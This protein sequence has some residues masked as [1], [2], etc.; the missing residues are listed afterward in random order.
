MKEFRVLNA[1]P[2]GYSPRARAILESVA[3]VE[4]IRVPVGELTEYVMGYDVLLVRLGHR[5]GHEVLTAGDRLKA[6][7]TATT[8]LDHIDLGAAQ[9]RG[10]TVL[11]L[12]GELDFLQEVHATAEHTWALLLA[13]VRSIP[14]SAESVR[15][16]RWD[17]D[18]FQG[19]ELHGREL[20]IVGLG[21]IGIKVARFGMAFG[22][23]VGAYDPLRSDWPAD[24][25]RYAE[26]SELLAGSD[27]LSLHV[28]LGKETH[29]LFGHAEF[30][31]MRPGAI[32]VNTARGGVLNETALLQA[33]DQGRIAGAALDVI[34]EEREIA[35]ARPH[36][37]VEYARRHANLLITP[38]LGG[39]TLESFEKTEVFMAKKTRDF[40][41]TQS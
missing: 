1:E 40:L 36:P 35:S 24:I 11:S 21:R 4:E 3:R 33:L 25:G 10:V 39:N 18:A 9:A 13:L 6:V 38:H 31:M 2:D 29:E 22:M 19:T 8:G 15:E 5:V 32:L 37:L 23:R 17:R 41:L 30:S 27:V 26:L 12:R 20:G 28:P 16:Y 7:V 34:V 14:A